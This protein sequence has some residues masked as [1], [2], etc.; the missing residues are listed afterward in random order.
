M[1]YLTEDEFKHELEVFSV[2]VQRLKQ[3]IERLIALKNEGKVSD[4]V[5]KEVLEEIINKVPAYNNK[6][7]EIEAAVDTRQSK[8][9]EE[10]RQIRHELETLEVK[11][12]IGAVPEDQYKVNKAS[13]TMRLQFLDEFSRY[14]STVMANVRDNWNKLS[15]YI[16]QYK[17]QVPREEIPLPPIELKS[18]K[19]EV[20]TQSFEVR[21]EEKSTTTQKSQPMPQAQKKICPRCGAENSPEATFC[22]NCGA[23][24][25]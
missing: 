2:Q 6:Y 9:K 22:Y 18:Q 19:I 4:E 20:P 25:V 16:A 1:E 12:T 13:Y 21:K 10:I 7:T 15:S 24:L 14:V 17:P 11:Y 5:F 23:K 8:I 3:Q